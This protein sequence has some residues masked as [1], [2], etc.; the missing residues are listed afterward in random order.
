[1]FYSTL[2]EDEK[3]RFKKEMQIFLEEIKITGIELRIDDEC[4]VL[5]AASAIIPIFSFP[6]WDY[7]NL[8]EILVYPANFNSNYQFDK[9]SNDNNI[10]GLVTNGG[11]T[12][13]LSKPSLYHGFRDSK[14]KLNVVFHEFSH[15]IDGADGFIDGIPAALSDK[16]TIKKWLEIINTE[17]LLIEKNKSDINPYALTNRAEFFAVVTE[18]FFENPQTMSIKH[19][20]LYKI[21]VKIF[22]QDTK[23]RYLSIIKNTFTPF[24]KKI[25]R[26][27]L[28]PCGSGKKYKKCCLNK[29][30]YS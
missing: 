5:I 12:M 25:G 7:D 26:N 11:L 18:Y 14:D 2:S 23:S 17:K 22:N 10:L 1:M 28:C 29:K 15:K 3:I 16:K 24:K 20:E 21:L 30:V 6:N 19:P 9:N 8:G 4:K 13:V 27:S